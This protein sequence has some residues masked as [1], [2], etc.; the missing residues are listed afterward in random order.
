[1]DGPVVTTSIGQS[2]ASATFTFDGTA[3]Q[4]VFLDVPSSTLPDDCGTLSLRGPDNAVIASG[5]IINGAGSIEGTVLPVT[6]TYSIV[7]DPR[8]GATGNIQLHLH[9]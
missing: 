8:T 7:V 2:G 9:T 5:C 6:G 4:R 3:G 1:M